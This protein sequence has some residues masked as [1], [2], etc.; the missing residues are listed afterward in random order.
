MG[1]RTFV[2][3]AQTK[4]SLIFEFV[5]FY[6]SDGLVTLLISVK[7][8]R[9]LLRDVAEQ[10]FQV[11]RLDQMFTRVRFVTADPALHIAYET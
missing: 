4:E 8:Q 7:V 10:R 3:A 9:G 11:G 5:G 6:S 2:V 1:L